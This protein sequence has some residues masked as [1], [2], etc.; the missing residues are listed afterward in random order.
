M[1]SVAIKPKIQLGNEAY[2]IISVNETS[3]QRWQD[4]R[5]EILNNVVNDKKITLS[6]KNNA[7]LNQ[8]NSLFMIDQ[9]LMKREILF[10]ILALTLFILTTLL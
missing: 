8:Y 4:V 6:L 3:V 1:V 2:Q 10:K 9:F 7:N 5:V